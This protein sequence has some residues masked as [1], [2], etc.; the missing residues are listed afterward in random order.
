MKE[1]KDLPLWNEFEKKADPSHIAMVQKLV[2]HA[3]NNL[4]LIRDTFPT[5][6]LHDHTH[7]ANVVRLMGELLGEK[8][9]EIT[10]LEGA[11]LIMSA[12]YHDIGMVFKEAERNNLQ[13]EEG[14]KPFLHKHPAAQIE[15]HKNDGELTSYVAEWY[16]RWCH[17]ER[18]YLFLNEIDEDLK[19]GKT[20]LKDA[21]GAVC[22]SH[23]KDI[24]ELLDEDRFNPDFLIGQAD[25]RFCAILLR[26]ADILD[27]DNSRAP[28]EIYSYLDLKERDNPIKKTSDVE[29]KKHLCSDG[30]IFPKGKSNEI[31]II[32][33]PEEPAVEHDLREFI[34]IIENEFMKCSNMLQRHVGRWHSLSLPERINTNNIK[35]KNY[36]YGEHRFSLDQEQVLELLMGENLYDNPFVFIREL[37]QNAIDTCRHRQFYEESQ[38]NIDYKPKIEIYDWRDANYNHWVRID[39]NGMGMNEEK[40]HNYLLKVGNSFYNSNQ[41]EAEKLEYKT[42]EGNDFT[43]ISRFGIGILSCFIAGDKVEVNTRHILDDSAL[44]LRLPGLHSF[45]TLQ[46]KENRH[47]PFEFESPT[48]KECDYRK[49]SG[50]SLLVRLKYRNYF[51]EFFG[52]DFNGI[53]G[54]EINF[55]L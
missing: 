37:L 29:W 15:I 49:E 32:A 5:Y 13:N 26:L 39:D 33:A 43:P 10:A 8:I 6:T 27:F 44:R 21:L 2:N 12:Y 17:P 34:K 14:F 22:E 18:V 55:F 38:G 20:P 51:D 11:I 25:L 23:G 35:S 45:Y 53:L 28:E 50:T 3:S 40:I 16:C 54:L 48:G 47:K 9:H 36:K 4:K 30:F 24:S 31:G 1:L 46:S 52:D 7:S 42:K 19:W 41:F